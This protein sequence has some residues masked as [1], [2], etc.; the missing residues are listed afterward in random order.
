VPTIAR[1]VAFRSEIAFT[2]VGVAI[3][4]P[5]ALNALPHLLCASTLGGVR[6]NGANHEDRSKCA[7]PYAAPVRCGTRWFHLTWR[8][9]PVVP[10]L[11][12][13]VTAAAFGESAAIR[14][15]PFTRA[16]SLEDIGYVPRSARLNFDTFGRL[17]VIHEG[18]YTVLNDN[19][20]MNQATD[21]DGAGVQMGN[22]IPAPD[23]QSY[24]GGRG[25]WGKAEVM[26]DGL[27]HAIPEVLLNPP[28]WIR[29][30][31]FGDLLATPD[32]IFFSSWNGVVYVDYATQRSQLFEIPIV[33]KLFSVGKVIYISGPEQPLKMIDVKRGTVVTAGGT[34]LDNFA[35][36]LAVP[37]DDKQ[38]L[39][40]LQ[41]GRLLVFDGQQPQPWPP[42]SRYGLSG[43]ISALHHT[44]DGR[45]AVAI[46]GRGLFLFSA[47]GELL[48]ALTTSEY[49]RITSLA[50]REPG[51]LWVA[52]E[53]AIQKI[54]YGSP[55]TTFGQK[56][57]LTLRWPIVERW[58][59]RT[60][61]ASD[62]DLYEAVAG[63]PGTPSRFE[64]Q[65]NQPPGGATCLTVCGPRMLVGSG[66]GIFSV[67]S[68]GH[69]E[70]VAFVANLMH[71][72]MIDAEHFYAIGRMEIAF[73]EWRNGRW[74]EAAPRI[75]GV[76]Y[77][78]IVHRIQRSIWIEMG[79]NGV[80][81]LTLQNGRLN[82]TI[83]KN[84]DWTK[85]QWVNVGSIDNTVVLSGIPGERRFFDER[86]GQWCDAPYLRTLFARSPY[87]I[88]RMEK[89]ATGTIW[90]THNDG[91]V[92]FS[93][94]GSGHDIDT[95]SFDVMNDR[96]P[97]VR[98][99][100]GND[101]WIS[102][103]QSLSHVERE[104]STSPLSTAVPKLV[105]LVDT[106][107][108]RELLTGASSFRY[109]L[110][111]PFSNNTITFTFTSGT[112]GW[113]RTPAYEYRL[114]RDE[115]WTRLA[116]SQQAFRDLHEGSYRLQV[117]ISGK[118]A[119]ANNSAVYPF[120]ILAPWYR[121]RPAYALFSLCAILMLAGIVWWFGG[122]ARRRHRV[123]ES[124]VQVRTSELQTAMEKLSE[125]TRKAATRA[126]RDRL[127]AEIHDSLQQGLTGAILQLDTTMTLAA[128]AGE[129]RSRLTVVR[130]MVSHVRQEMQYAV[131][132]IESPL[133][134]GKELA[135]ALNNLPAFLDSDATTIEVIV[136]G[137]AVPLTRLANH[138]LL[139]ITQEATSN[140]LRHAKATR[141]A[142]RLDYGAAA[143]CLEI[144]D[145]GVGF[146][147]DDMSKKLI[148]HFGLGGIQARSK[149]LG[150]TLTIRS[151][152]HEGAT[153]RVEVPM[154][155]N[156][157]FNETSGNNEF[158][159]A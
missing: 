112:D 113:R 135:D 31:L 80:A 40:Y 144:A 145:D 93:P 60:F 141:I 75:P 155:P 101:V 134:E 137:E 35:V 28:D 46:T 88:T 26:A 85:A 125:E 114:D 13:L 39:V 97:I 91:L 17:A 89:D 132:D 18:V 6:G 95:S 76:P 108:G 78:A 58:D 102:A 152:L 50:N 129:V 49:H 124:V 51:V 1:F 138:N 42:Q 71:L 27:L 52:T 62:G 150:G 37:L 61:V 126:E 5:S 53:D 72:V 59:G 19:V 65:R 11:V 103:G 106:R 44:V 139:R 117:R 67:T 43:H 131:W 83:V 116:G 23:G 99:L 4:P 55:L 29:T 159:L 146:C 22:V 154:A 130:N 109:P 15:F 45:V 68:D 105:S 157:S 38:T 147:P 33:S 98:V 73:F 36:E 84:S 57:G 94:T 87:W 66:R 12:L 69:F 34:D 110:R 32:G 96:Y 70:N 16:Y 111:L 24:Y 14:G 41:D 127:A 64:L 21:T 2:C 82:L 119:N 118:P 115:P 74:S 133:L 7:V 3:Q 86:T 140:A 90:A 158:N 128:V 107:S 30:A 121:T 9:W 104:W 8:R 77:A 123:L 149:K 148:G 79:G 153:V 47:T 151:S 156:T 48:L 81:R 120:E 122:V 142:I 20:W 56:L 25:T 54:L 10:V 100:D 63:S 136:T 92:R 143:V